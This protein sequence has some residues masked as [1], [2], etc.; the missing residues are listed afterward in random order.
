M[1]GSVADELLKL[2]QLLDAGLITRDEFEAQKRKLLGGATGPAPAAP[3]RPAHTGPD[4]LGIFSRS[5]APAPRQQ[6]PAHFDGVFELERDEY[7]IAWHWHEP[8]GS[9]GCLFWLLMLLS[10]ATVVLIPFVIYAMVRK[11]QGVVERQRQFLTNKRAVA[12]HNDKLKELWY[13]DLVAAWLDG[14]QN[15]MLIASPRK[16]FS[17]GL[18]KLDL[19]HPSS[20]KL[21]FIGLRDE[22]ETFARI[23]LDAAAQRRPLTRY[24]P[25]QGPLP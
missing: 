10:T 1:A 9:D 22:Q 23:L 3:A 21:H 20:T 16:R 12:Y 8:S 24:A 14:K 4:P 2:K 5:A 17:L 13:D 11:S 6:L 7:V 25:L 19:V 15:S 18:G